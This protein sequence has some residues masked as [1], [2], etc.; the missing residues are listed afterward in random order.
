MKF[1]GN[2]KADFL[3]RHILRFAAGLFVFFMPGNETFINEIVGGLILIWTTVLS[4]NEPGKTLIQKVQGL[5]EHLTG[6]VMLWL[7]QFNKETAFEVL[8]S[9]QGLL[10]LI[11]PM[12][13]SFVKRSDTSI[14]LTKTKTENLNHEKIV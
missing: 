8:Q 11:L 3:F 5:L 6:F 14:A 2:T 1:F 4:W 9:I 10:A 13:F 12:I 7:T